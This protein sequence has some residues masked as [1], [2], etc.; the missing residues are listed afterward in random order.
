MM[1]DDFIGECFVALTNIPSLKN[2]ASFRDVPVMQMPLRRLHKNMQPEA[3]EV[4]V[5]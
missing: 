1:K 3:F 2:L 4:N 5:P